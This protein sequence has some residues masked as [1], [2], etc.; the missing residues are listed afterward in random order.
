MILVVEPD[1]SFAEQLADALRSAGWSTEL[2]GGRTQ[3]IA[4]MAEQQPEIVIV[5]IAVPEAEELL[6][7]CA[8]GRGGPGS[9]A[10]VPAPLADVVSADDYRA[11]AIITKPFSDEQLKRSIEACVMLRRQRRSMRTPTSAKNK[12]LSS[13]DIFGDILLEVESSVVSQSGPQMIPEAAPVATVGQAPSV[14][15]ATTQAATQATPTGGGPDTATVRP[16]RTKLSSDD[17]LEERLEQ[18]LSGL[19]DQRPATLSATQRRAQEADSVEELLDR[20]LGPLAQIKRSLPAAAARPPQQAT[21]QA[22]RLAPSE[23]TFATPTAP[24]KSVASSQPSPAPPDASVPAAAPDASPDLDIPGLD[25]LGLMT[26]EQQALAAS[27]AGSGQ[28]A[29][30]DEPPSDPLLPAIEPPP[31]LAMPAVTTPIAF[32]AP[33][34]PYRTQMLPTLPSLPTDGGQVLGDYT[35]IERIAVGGMAEVWK[36]RRSGV[37]GFEKIVAIKR[38]LA[39][40]TDSPEL[41]SMLIDEAKLAARLSNPNI[42][43]IYDLGKVEDDFFIAMEYVDG[44]DLRSALKAAREHDLPMPVGVAIMV[45]ARLARALDYAHRLKGDDQRELGL[46]HRDVSPQNILISNEGDIKLCDFGIAKAVTSIG[47]TQMGAL[48]GKLQYMSPEQAWGKKLDARSDIFSLGAVLF[49]VLTGTKLFAGDSEIGVLDAVRDCRITSPR[50]IDPDIPEDAERV[51]LRALAKAPEDRYQSAGALAAELESVLASLPRQLTQADLAAYLA[52][53]GT[54]QA[55]GKV[56]DKSRT[57]STDASSDSGAISQ[58]TATETAHT[59]EGAFDA[60]AEEGAANHRGRWWLVAAS[61]AVVVLGGLWLVI[62][63]RSGPVPPNATPTSTGSPPPAV[64][65]TT[66]EPSTAG[67]IGSPSTDSVPT[68][69]LAAG[70]R[71]NGG[72]VTAAEENPPPETRTVAGSGQAAANTVATPTGPDLEKMVADELARR[73]ADIEAKMVAEYRREQQRLATELAEAQARSSEA[74]EADPE[75]AAETDEPPP[76]TPSEGGGF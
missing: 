23:G 65:P 30:R 44:T 22:A 18:T 71:P 74:S 62:V 36:A 11:D 39:H 24:D 56:N 19:F 76:G 26:A 66:S 4:L 33:P 67:G 38:V 41:V 40:L 3:A 63:G 45:T 46:I 28:D 59:E 2:V 1:R 58:G 8:A 31:P 6:A 21:P 12:H 43:Q 72:V 37:E 68:G 15:E 47:H 48:K 75:A 69:T 70:A 9:I 13:Q 55:G 73:T 10:V 27:S 51:V 32:D 16:A 60:I 53:L 7:A 35:L 5:D 14:V 17:D 49:E 64:A 57:P 61:F 50:A 25:A 34:D 52:Q 29:G 54:A 20:T 42:V